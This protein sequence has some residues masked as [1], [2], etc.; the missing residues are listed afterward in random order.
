MRFKFSEKNWIFD[1][2]NTLHNADYFAYPQI[3][4][5]MTHY[6]VDQLN[7]DLDEANELRNHYWQKYGA[8]LIGLTKH[9]KVDPRH[10]LEVTHNFSVQK[11]NLSALPQLR[12]I[13]KKIKGSKYI[14]S[15]GPRVYIQAVLKSL[16]IKNFFSNIFSVESTHFNP[17]PSKHGFNLIMKKSGLDPRTCIMV[18]DTLSNLYAAKNLGLRTVWIS[19]EIF[20][21][22]WVDIKLP[23]VGKLINL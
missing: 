18:E 6:I 21:P 2:D 17:K 10:F 7:V 19:R 16:A 8:T 3:N 20:K 13:L 12:H 1:L 11:N 9:H 22:S 14:F 4:R 5:L 15:N 23:H